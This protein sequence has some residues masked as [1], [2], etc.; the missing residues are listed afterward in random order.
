LSVA[1]S[2]NPTRQRPLRIWPGIAIVLLQWLARFGVPFVVPEA[3][4][5]RAVGAV[6]G[7]L[8]VVVWWACFSRARGFD[9][10]SGVVFLV[11]AP[12]MTWCF[13]HESIAYGGMGMLFV[14]YATPPLCLAFVTWA[15]VGRGLP[16]RPRRFAMVATILLACGV[17]TL[18]RTTGITGNRL[19][20]FEWRWARTPEE[21]LVDRPARNGPPA[22]LVPVADSPGSTWPGFRGA[23][24]DGVVRGLRIATDWKT[25]PP[26]E[27][28]RRPIGPGWSSFAVRQGL[29]FTQEQRGDEEVV[30]CYD[31]AT[32]EPVW[33]HRDLTRF[34]ESGTG[35]GPRAT[36]TLSGDRL[37]TLG[38]TG[39]LNALD[40]TDGTVRWSRNVATD[41]AAEVPLWGFS[42]SPLVVHDMVIVAAAG[43]LVGYDVVNGE[44]R[45]LGPNRGG[46]WGSYSSPHLLTIDGIEQVL[47]LSGA[48][49]T[50]VAPATGAL[51]WEYS[52]PGF[53]MV[54]PA[55]TAEGDL[56]IGADD[57]GTR[58]IAVS[59][60]A[61][62]WTIEEQWTS[63]GLK[64]YFNDFVIEDNHAFGFD[65]GI[66]ACIDLA[67]G[68]RKWKGGRYGHGQLVLL[69][70][71]GLLLVISERGELAL[72]EATPDRFAEFA[73]IPV[74]EGKTWN[75]PVLT[76]DLLLLR[77]DRQMVALRL[78]LAGRGH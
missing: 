45:W 32:G 7:G 54:Q 75:H 39:V 41:T 2:F 15:V 16:D 72:V 44:P 31:A 66:L 76:G 43:Q 30:A 71:Q 19:A 18:C 62:G 59:Q 67:D 63:N 56:L 28:W 36:P 33:T 64:P 17:W 9:R 53:S 6:L 55:M 69:A 25:A 29:L 51:L 48:G 38:A 14:I 24:R 4:A 68:E 35:A 60:R 50:S 8:A 12:V 46:S 78:P 65:G 27:L 26:V 22:S 20:E 3:T 47:L 37:Y 58:R 74:I 34:W 57:L 73:R 61:A 13:S 70:D 10:W 23:D 1:Q 42:S 77:N 49:L 52:W 40:A 21:R 11:V 5:F